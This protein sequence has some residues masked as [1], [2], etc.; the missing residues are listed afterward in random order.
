LFAGI[1]T[2]DLFLQKN[3][4][5]LEKIESKGPTCEVQVNK[6]ILNILL[7]PLYREQ[8]ADKGLI[9]IDDVLN[10]GTTLIYAVRHF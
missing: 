1:A 4:L 5:E 3:C 6:Q 10:S 2:T 8:Y 9:L 7:Q